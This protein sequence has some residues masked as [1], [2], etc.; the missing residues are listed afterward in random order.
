M[1]ETFK[2]IVSICGI[3][4]VITAI[5]DELSHTFL[6]I[7]PNFLFRILV[8]VVIVAIVYFNTKDRQGC[9]DNGDA[10]Q[11]TFHKCPSCK[12]GKNS[13]DLGGN[14]LCFH[15]DSCGYVQCVESPSTKET[16]EQMFPY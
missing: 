12:V 15:C 11:T 1:K 16:R 7:K 8:G 6:E 14:D 9:A 4:F 5:T 13:R 2:A 10:A 3:A